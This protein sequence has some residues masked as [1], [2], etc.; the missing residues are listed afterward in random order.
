MSTAQDVFVL[1][2]Y[3]TLDLTTG[4]GTA[5]PVAG[6]QGV[7][8]VP[9]VSLERLFTADSTKTEEKKQFE[10][11]VDVGIEY[12]KWADDA[13]LV[14]QW[15][16][17]GGGGT[18]TSWADT[19]DPQEFELS[20]TFDSVGGDRTIDLTVVGITFEELPIMEAERGEF[21]SRDLSGTGDDI[22]NYT[23]TDN[24]TV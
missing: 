3:T 23:V 6:I 16:G 9:S 12:S 4:G 1:D 2:D 21:I 11:T 14:Q 7:T 8:I 17:G 10:H 19:S 24:T 5:T 15:L 13:A 22:T 20:G 18:S